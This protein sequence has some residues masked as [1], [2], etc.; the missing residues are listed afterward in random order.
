MGIA[1]FPAK[2]KRGADCF[3]ARWRH[4]CFNAWLHEEV[5]KNTVE[6]A[7]LGATEIERTL[8]MK[9]NKKHIGSSIESWLEEEGILES[10]TNFAVKSVLA[11]Q[12]AQEMKKK[13]FS[14]LKMAEAMKTSR[15]QLDRL[16]DPES[17]NVTLTTMQKA[18]NAVGKSLRVELV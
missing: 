17:G 18:A 4:A 9:L 10:S 3:Y 14:K 13:K 7:D 1:N 11:W 16:L 12:I 8:T 15:A 2:Q 5:A 6:G